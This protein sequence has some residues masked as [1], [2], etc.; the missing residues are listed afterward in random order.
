MDG[1]NSTL[2]AGHLEI[3]ADKQP[4]STLVTETYHSTIELGQFNGQA[5][6]IKRCRN[7]NDPRTTTRFRNEVDALKLVASH[8]S[9]LSQRRNSFFD[10][11]STSRY[12]STL[13]SSGMQISVNS[14]SHY[15]PNRARV[16]T[17]TWIAIGSRHSPQETLP[18]YGSK[19]LAL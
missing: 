7:Q 11:C 13:R 19:Y 15:A 6:I 18:H 17:S 4:S 5:A 8:V 14:L 12:R 3:K 2:L 10:N 16:W 1:D 9:C